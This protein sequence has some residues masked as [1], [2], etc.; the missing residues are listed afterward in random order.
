MSLTPLQI[1]LLIVSCSAF[2]PSSLMVLQ[3]PS[4]ISIQP[5]NA[6][7]QMTQDNVDSFVINMQNLLADGDIVDS[8]TITNDLSINAVDSTSVATNSDPSIGLVAAGAVVSIAL[9]GSMVV[10]LGKS[11]DGKIDNEDP[12]QQ[13]NLKLSESSPN[14][15]L[16]ITNDGDGDQ[17][18]IIDDLTEDE[19]N[20]LE[21]Y[22]KENEG[23]LRASLSKL[24]GLVRTT[25]TSLNEAEEKLKDVGEEMR[26]LEDKYE[27][28]QNALK[29]KDTELKKTQS[30]LR[31]TQTMLR[32]TSESLTLVEQERDS[33]EAE[34]KT[35]STT[36]SQ[37]E[38]ERKSIRKLG[39]VALDLSKD[40]VRKRFQGFK[41]LLSRNK[42]KEDVE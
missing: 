13:G 22:E 8:S 19:D 39:R 17:N 42:G 25:R 32:N 6:K 7:L 16:T 41:S 2:V 12:V 38:E 10:L 26:N 5:K 15:V 31:E 24:V 28:E 34:L 36:L 14:R 33:I 23:L 1:A 20:V 21:A 4:R 9:I 30:S 29:R 35:T 18:R 27:L 37:L 3:R 40:R 11:D